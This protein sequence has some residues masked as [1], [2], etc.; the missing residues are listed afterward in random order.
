MIHVL[1]LAGNGGNAARWSRLP[2][3]LSIDADE[4]VVLHP[5]ALPGFDGI[6]MPYATPTVHDFAD[7]LAAEVDNFDGPRVF[8]GTGIGGS[9][10]LQAAQRAGLADAYIFHSP[11]GPNLDTRLLPKLMKP[12]VLRRMVKHAIGGA[13]GRLMLKRRW[14]DIIPADDIDRF[15]QGYLDCDAFEVM[16]DI[17]TAKWFDSLDPIAE[18]AVLMWGAEDAVLGSNLADGFTNVLPNAEVVIEEAWGHYPMLEDPQSF[19][20]SISS[21]SRRLVG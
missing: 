2:Q 12:A 6:P 1:A 11:V 3:P 8:F 18:P 5:I 13:P 21:I 17:L 16:W 4:P 14:R 19:A 20:A 9:I 15:T 10:G 7:W